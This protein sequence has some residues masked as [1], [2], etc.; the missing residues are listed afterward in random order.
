MAFLRIL[1]FTD[2]IAFS[3]KTL[4]TSPKKTQKTQVSSNFAVTRELIFHSFSLRF[5]SIIMANE[6]TDSNAQLSCQIQEKF[7]ANQQTPRI[8][9]QKDSWRRE[10]ELII[11]ELYPSCRLVLCGSSANGF[12]SID[13]DIDLI[14]TAESREGAEDY[15][16]RRIGSLFTRTPR[17]YETRV[18][19]FQSI[20]SISLSR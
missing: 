13:S 1:L 16:L 10:M 11:Q 14:L 7:S 3:Q 6:N 18:W 4:E 15:M 5:G 2:D 12:G 9:D 8:Y 19:S 17:R 20:E